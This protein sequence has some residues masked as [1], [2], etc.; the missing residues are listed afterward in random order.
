[1]IGLLGLYAG[2]LDW[3]V[4]L[5]AVVGGAAL[6][7]FGIGFLVRLAGRFLGARTVPR[8]MLNLVRLL[9]AVVAGWVVWLLVFG[10]G[11][12][13]IGGPGGSSIGGAPGS[14]KGTA[15]DAA[16]APQPEP[17]ERAGGTLP[18]VILGGTQVREGRFYEVPGEKEPLTLSALKEVLKTRQQAGNLRRIEIVIY[19]SSVYKESEAVTALEDWAR[20]HDLDVTMSFPKAGAP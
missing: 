17:A 6:G 19:G 9:A 12:A 11:G 2:P 14:G 4:R 5:L 3:V 7:G 13:G 16:R 20:Q 15:P 18:I 1:M 10:T 8:T